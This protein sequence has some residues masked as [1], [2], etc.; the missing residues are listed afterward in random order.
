VRHLQAVDPAR[1]RFGLPVRAERLL[2][3]VRHRAAYAVS[4]APFP[5]G[6]SVSYWLWGG[7]GQYG[8]QRIP[9]QD[10]GCIAVYA[11]DGNPA[12]GGGPHGHTGLVVGFT[13]TTITCIESRG[14]VGVCLMTRSRSFWQGFVSIDGMTEAV[15]TG[16]L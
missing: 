5:L 4:G 3:E 13:P 7:A 9:G 2:D 6:S 15:L 11:E 1:G 16:M 10:V 8:L 14:G 12:D